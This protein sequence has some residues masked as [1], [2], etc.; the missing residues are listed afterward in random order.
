MMSKYSRFRPEAGRA[1][2]CNAKRVT[3]FAVS[4]SRLLAAMYGPHKEEV[5]RLRAS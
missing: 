1:W 3:G 5:W 2:E 4:N